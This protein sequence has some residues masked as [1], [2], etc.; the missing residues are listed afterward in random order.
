MESEGVTSASISSVLTKDDLDKMPK[1]VRGKY[2]EFFGTFL[3]IKA[4]YE[5]L[6]STSGENGD[7]CMGWMC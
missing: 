1:D 6:K 4:L 5:T 2:E 3:E 7:R